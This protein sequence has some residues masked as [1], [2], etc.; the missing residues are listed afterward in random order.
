MFALRT[1]AVITARGGSKGIP[2]KNIRMLA[3][4]PMIA[5]TIEAALASGRL[6][7]V[8]LSTDDEE[9]AET[10][11][12]LGAEVPFMRPAVLSGDDA[13]SIAVMEHVLGWL[14]RNDGLPDYMLLLQ[15]TSPLRTAEDV[16]N[17]IALA[18]NHNSDSVVGVTECSPH[19]FLARTIREDR[20]LDEFFKTEH[21]V[22]RRQDFPPAYA[23]NGAIYLNRPKSLRATR[24]L[25]PPGAHAYIMPPERSIDVDSLWQFDIAD[26]LLSRREKG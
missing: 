22:Y 1:I 15:P 9:I 23:I 19:P 7:R 24:T 20:T 14:E 8:I 12:R 10:A 3:G 13:P 16:N 21:R 17:A 2:R 4:K 18:T 5:W 26:A 6:E 25:I 11:R